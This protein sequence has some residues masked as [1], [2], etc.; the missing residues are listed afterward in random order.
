M[1]Y[2]G[3]LSPF[4]QKP[5]I[6]IIKNQNIRFL[7]G[8]VVSNP[9]KSSTGKT[10]SVKFLV[11]KVGSLD[12]CNGILSSGEGEVDLYFPV[13]YVEAY[14][15]GKLFSLAHKKQK[16]LNDENSFNL[17]LPIIEYG[18]NL[19]L[20]VSFLESQE[21]KNSFYVKN[22]VSHCYNSKIDFYRA[23]SR[24]ILKRI[25][26]NWN[27][28]GGLLLALLSGS[29]EYISQEIDEDFRKAGLAHILALSGMHLSIFASL[30][31]KFFKKTGD[32][33]SLVLVF[34]F[35]WFA[36]LSPSL[37]RALITMLLGYLFKFLG[38]KADFIGVLSISFLL[39]ISIFPSHIYNYG[40][41]LS[42]GALIGI[43]IGQ[44]YFFSFICKVFPKKIANYFTSSLGAQIITAPICLFTFGSCS[45]IGIISSVIVSPVANG[46]LTLGIISV[47][48]SLL[49]PF[50]LS[51]FGC[52]MEQ[53]YVILTLMVNFFSKFPIIQI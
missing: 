50:L 10:Y 43:E 39:Q 33:V 38:I 26:F 23:Y 17:D 5:F 35:V 19:A 47:F 7:E 1:Y 42:Y 36:G 44:T 21:G 46:F 3:L 6:T 14:Y 8:K 52:I 30:P 18:V 25:L 16:T 51:P 13:E 34:L 24:L 12:S 31:K 40:F 49:I 37:L 20:N 41:I 4:V 2:S 15:P 22:I 53:V 32:V 48:L 11:K 29:K 9:V 27:D 45:P 28:C